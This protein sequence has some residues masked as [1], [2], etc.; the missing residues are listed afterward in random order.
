M[1]ELLKKSVGVLQHVSPKAASEIVWHHFTKPGKSRFTPAQEALLDQ[2]VIGKVSHLG[3]DIVTYRWGEEGPRV[4]LCHGW[5]SKTAD[6]RRLIEKLLTKGFVVEGIDMKAHGKSEGKHTALPEIRDIIKNHYVKNG[7]YHTIVGYS[8]GGLA[9]SIFLSEIS[10]EFHP[11]NLVLLAA[12][13]H[14]RYFFEG[15]IKELGYSERVYKEMVEIALDR[16]KQSVDY[17]DIRTKQDEL[18]GI[19]VHL[20]YDEDDDT[21]P[22]SMGL[23]LQAIFPNASFVHTKGLGHYR[24]ISFREVTACITSHLLEQ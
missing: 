6:F 1:I 14:A 5:N 3:Y 4:L 12:P 22:F 10:A 20:V 23:D 15:V 16:Y 17:F 8:M 24:V 21:V 7:P 2:A 11:K 19:N 18:K 9:A 13:S